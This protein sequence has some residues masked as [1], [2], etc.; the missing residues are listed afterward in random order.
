MSFETISAREKEDI[1]KY[2]GKALEELT[3]DEF[4]Q[5]VRELRS[6]YHPDNFEKFEDPTVREMATERFQ[7]IESLTAKIEAYLRGE[8]TTATL[9]PE[10]HAFYAFDG[11]KIEVVTSDK[12]LKYDLFGTF[13]RWLRMGEKF[14][15]PGAANAFIVMDED[16]RGVRIG[17]N[18]TIRMYLTFGREDA[19]ETIVDWLYQHI[20]GRASY[21]II[22]GA[23]IEVDA[24]AMLMAVRRPALLM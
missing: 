16:H 13:Y 4:R 7:Q 22:H 10:R 9:A 20:R 5:L 3:H 21:L 24:T 19:V 15:I 6:K 18:E 8:A 11:M 2:F 12:D 1:Q 23:K 17:Y 14:K